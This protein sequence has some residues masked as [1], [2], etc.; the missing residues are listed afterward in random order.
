MDSEMFYLY[1]VSHNCMSMHQKQSHKYMCGIRILLKEI[2]GFFMPLYISSDNFTAS[3]GS[4]DHKL[5]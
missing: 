4:K 1:F 5:G 3:H 2:P